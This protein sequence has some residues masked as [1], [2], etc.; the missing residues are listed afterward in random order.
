M[1]AFLF[2]FLLLLYLRK[3]W[4]RPQ[5]ILFF[6]I[7]VK[8]TLRQFSM[9]STQKKVRITS[10]LGF[11]GGAVPRNVIQDDANYSRYFLKKNLKICTHMELTFWLWLNCK[12]PIQA[13]KNHIWC[14]TN[15]SFAI[16][17]RAY[18][19]WG[20][21]WTEF[22][23]KYTSKYHTTEQV[24]FWNLL[25][26]FLLSFLAQQIHFSHDVNLWNL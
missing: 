26:Y 18:F 8:V 13:F 5:G 1:L 7:V 6:Q 23:V 2:F 12:Y 17:K 15:P 19:K 24:M 9:F 20:K 10:S 3:L 16:P 4:E 11:Q 22:W 21:D 25:F 14:R